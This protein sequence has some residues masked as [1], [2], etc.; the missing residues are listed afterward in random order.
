MF[1]AHSRS[2]SHRNASYV[3]VL[4]STLL[5]TAILGSSAWA[6]SAPAIGNSDEPVYASSEFS[7]V[8]ENSFVWEGNVRIIQGK[9]ILRA[10]RIV[11]TLTDSGDINEITAHDNVRYSDGEQAISGDLGIYSEGQRTLTITGDVIVTQ[12]KNVFTAGK[13]IYWL[14]SGRVR[15]TPKT[16][17]RVRG[18]FYTD[19]QL[20]QRNNQGDN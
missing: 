12:G 2:R 6:Q 19:T 13:A 3:L 10:D 11:G 20:P 17:Q 7:E 14:D 9:A 5:W 15:F 1:T 8:T 4:I 16:G 18:I